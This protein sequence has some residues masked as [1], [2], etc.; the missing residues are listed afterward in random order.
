MAQLVGDLTGG[1]VHQLGDQDFVGCLIV[2]FHDARSPLFEF[3]RAHDAV[4]KGGA[5]LFGSAGARVDRS[6]ANLGRP[7][8]GIAHLGSAGVDYFDYISVQN[9]LAVLLAYGCI[10]LRIGFEQ[11]GF[12]A[13]GLALGYILGFISSF[14]CFNELAALPCR[15]DEVVRVVLES[16]DAESDGVGFVLGTGKG[17]QHRYQHQ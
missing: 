14:E 7:G 15:V 13:G 3:S 5:V 6:T 9:E 10:G 4:G 2:S 16:G 17:G 8:S 11:N 12:Y 1:L